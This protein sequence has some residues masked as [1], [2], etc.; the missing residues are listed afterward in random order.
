[1]AE[2]IRYEA[3]CRALAEARSVDEAKEIRDKA[4]ALR[5]Y[6]RMAKN[7]QLEVDAAEIRF[8]AERRLGQMMNGK[9]SAQGRRSDLGLDGPQVETLDEQGIDKNMAKR[10]R[11]LASIPDEK[12]ESVMAEHRDAQEAVTNKTILTLDKL[13]VH[14][15][16]ESA[17]HYTPDIVLERVV[18]V[19]GDIDLDPCADPDHAVPAVHHFSLPD[20]DGLAEPWF[21]RVFMNPPY[22]KVI[23]EWVDKFTAESIDQ[24]IALVPARPDTQWWSWLS[25][26]PVCFVRGRLTFKGNQ[27]PAPFP[28]ALF[29]RG[30]RKAKFAREFANLGSIWSMTHEYRSAD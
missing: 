26:Y 14:H 9:P 15:S 12:F 5:A 6:A 29:Y 30:K 8:R 27:D 16:S 2:L 19:M 1:M 21:G 25:P 23:G 22:G 4:A 28:S 10:A 11:K 18:R 3:A 20:H 24:G 17:E 7:R 13:K